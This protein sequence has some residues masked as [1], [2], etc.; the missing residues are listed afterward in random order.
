[1]VHSN[2]EL[3]TDYWRMRVPAF[4]CPPRS[5]VDPTHFIDLLPQV[6]ILGRAAA[7]YAVLAAEKRRSSEDDDVVAH[8]KVVDVLKSLPRVGA[9]RATKVMERL[10]IAPNRRLRG[11]GIHQTA[12]LI[13]EFTVG[14]PSPEITRGESRVDLCLKKPPTSSSAASRRLR[15]KPKLR[16]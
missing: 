7:G 13:A 15:A 10:D 8:T 9:V 6:F 1:M 14:G 4:G 3:L 12:A 2:T 11:L 16:P 5:S